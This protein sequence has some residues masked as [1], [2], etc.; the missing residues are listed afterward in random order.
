M[1]K[2]FVFF[3]LISLLLSLP[4]FGFGQPPLKVGALVPFTD[5]WGDSGRECAKGMLD[6]SKWLNQRGGILGRRLEIFLIDDTFQPDETLAAY[7][8]LNEADQILLLYIY[9]TGT[10]L[11]LLPHTHFNRIPTLVTS[12]PSHLAESLKYPYYF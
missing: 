10:A 9:S 4:E 6:A 3:F 1:K 8:K 2:L 12:F 7:R 11:A 5:R